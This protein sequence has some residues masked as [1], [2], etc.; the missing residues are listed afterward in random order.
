[1]SLIRI[2]G[3]TIL[4][5]IL[6]ESER[7]EARALREQAIHSQQ[8]RR[9]EYSRQSS[10]L[11]S[12][13]TERER[14][15]N[16]GRTSSSTRRSVLSTPKS[17]RTN[18]ETS[19]SSAPSSGGEALTGPED[20]PSAANV[21]VQTESS[22][23]LTASTD[24][25]SYLNTSLD[26]SLDTSTSA[27]FNTRQQ[28]S[29][30]AQVD[31]ALLLSVSPEVATD[32]ILGR[33]HPSTVLHQSNNDMRNMQPDSQRTDTAS[34]TLTQEQQSAEKQ[35]VPEGHDTTTASVSLSLASFSEEGGD[36]SE[37]GLEASEEILEVSE[38]MDGSEEDRDLSLPSEAESDWHRDE[39]DDSHTQSSQTTS[40]KSGSGSSFDM[41]RDLRVSALREGR[42]SSWSMQRDSG[43]SSS[44]SDYL[45][46]YL[47]LLTSRSSSSLGLQSTGVSVAP[48]KMV[49]PVT[50]SSAT[51]GVITTSSTE[52]SDQKKSS[53][54]RD[55]NNMK[56]KTGS[57]DSSESFGNKEENES[58]KKKKEFLKGKLIEDLKIDDRDKK[59]ARDRLEEPRSSSAASERKTSKRSRERRLSYQHG[60][61]SRS[62]GSKYLDSYLG[63]L[64]D[65]AWL[66]YPTSIGSRH[67][68]FLD[69]DDY[70]QTVRPQQVKKNRGKSQS[71]TEQTESSASEDS[72]R[73]DSS[74]TSSHSPHSNVSTSIKEDVTEMSQ[75][76][77]Q[78]KN[79]S[80][81]LES[82]HTAKVVH[83][84]READAQPLQEQ[85]STFIS[86]PKE[87]M[88]NSETE[89]NEQ[90]LPPNTLS[91]Q[92]SQERMSQC[93]ESTEK[94]DHSPE[95]NDLTQTTIPEKQK[96]NDN[97][98]K[99][100]NSMESKKI[101]SN[102]PDSVNE[103]VIA[104]SSPNKNKIVSSESF[105]KG[106][107]QN[108]EGSFLDDN[109]NVDNVKNLESTVPAF[110]IG[111]IVESTERDDS[112]SDES[113]ETEPSTI[114]YV[115]DYP[116][117]IRNSMQKELEKQGGH[118]TVE[119]D[120]TVLS[121]EKNSEEAKALAEFE[122]LEIAHGRTEGQVSVKSE[123]ET[124][125]QKKDNTD[126]PS[127]H[128]D[129]E[130]YSDSISKNC[131]VTFDGDKDEDNVK[132]NESRTLGE[133]D[134]K[135]DIVLQTE[136][137]TNLAE[138][139]VKQGE[140]KN[141]MDPSF[142]CQV[143]LKSDIVE[144]IPQVE[145]YDS[146]E[147]CLVVQVT[148]RKDSR[149][150]QS[151]WTGSKTESKNEDEVVEIVAQSLEKPNN[152]MELALETSNSMRDLVP[153][154]VS[155]DAMNQ[156]LNLLRAKQ[157]Q[158]L[159]AL[160]RRQEEEIRQFIQQLQRVS[161]KQLQAFLSASTITC[162][163]IEGRPDDDLHLRS[164]GNFSI[165]DVDNFKISK[166][167]GIRGSSPGRSHIEVGLY[168]KNDD[169]SINNEGRG[170]K[171]EQSRYLISSKPVEDVTNK[172]DN[173]SVLHPCAST[174]NTISSSCASVN[175]PS[176]TYSEKI[177]GADLKPRPS[178]HTNIMPSYFV[179]EETKKAADSLGNVVMT[180]EASSNLSNR[181]HNVSYSGSSPNHAQASET[182]PSLHAKNNN[183]PMETL[184]QVSYVNGNCVSYGDGMQYYRLFTAD[185]DG[186]VSRTRSCRQTVLEPVLQSNSSQI[187]T[188]P[189]LFR[190]VSGSP[191]PSPRPTS[192]TG[193]LAEHPEMFSD[194][195]VEMNLQHINDWGPSE[196]G[197][198][199]HTPA[200]QHSS[201]THLVTVPHHSSGRCHSNTS[202]QRG[203]SEE[204]GLD[205]VP[206]RES[207][208]NIYH[209][210][211][212]Q[213]A[214]FIRGITL[215]QAC[216]RRFLIQRLFRTKFVQEQLAILAEI[217][218][219]AQQ[220]H[221]DILTDNIHKGDVDFHKALYNQVVP[222]TPTLHVIPPRLRL[223]SFISSSSYGPLQNQEGMARE[224][225]R[226]V[227]VVLTVQE[228]MSL[229][230]RDRQLWKMQQ[231]RQLPSTSQASPTHTNTVRSR[232]GATEA[233]VRGT[234]TR[235][236]KK[237]PSPP[238]QRSQQE[239]RTRAA[240]HGRTSQLV[241]PSVIT[242]QASNLSSRSSVTSE[243]RVSP[244]GGKLP[245]HVERS[246][247]H[248]D[249]PM[250]HHYM[251]QSPHIRSPSQD[252][253]SGHHTGSTRCSVHPRS[254]SA[255]Q[256]ETRSGSH[257][258]S[259]S[260]SHLPGSHHV[261]RSATHQSGK[262][263][264]RSSS[265]SGTRS[266]CT[267][268]STSMSNS[269]RRV[270]PPRS[271][272]K[273]SLAG[274]RPWR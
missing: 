100:V 76:K 236:A 229:I 129:M 52:H 117:E 185:D 265:I 168:N 28:S 227:F 175:L 178:N 207:A 156:V 73:Q 64:T 234:P 37:E 266:T 25:R 14:A 134:I 65:D 92:Q 245:L 139:I 62:V 170:T 67:M 145:I 69:S 143:P 228:Q 206:E 33:V 132:A 124:D 93:P 41:P 237:R 240:S 99:N 18:G 137:T 216:V 152:E 142:N 10:H 96:E 180:G 262:T 39:T 158:E 133:P 157:R 70:M 105:E 78:E 211:L 226:R 89:R 274:R 81:Q 163:S 94:S 104:S 255:S 16:E 192:I 172:T 8:Q 219:L 51:R 38:V 154:K 196:V 80:C 160:R 217:A 201:G 120:N 128:K 193:L 243:H 82:K 232:S 59:K 184:D 149:N 123:N 112:S 208:A 215:L 253:K 1:M 53:V 103:N 233:R 198:R 109:Y 148:E 44:H 254:S 258:M 29:S 107:Q 187:V 74:T 23:S 63:N 60:D 102:V 181:S 127:S 204:G 138:Q 68:V 269:P 121:R 264:S 122:Q 9:K 84:A 88:E 222:F 116:C 66:Q 98:D 54:C 257:H 261:A 267:A 61:P 194:D 85:D 4:S 230:R 110:K 159:D 171:E 162:G 191:W 260:T 46:D 165:S 248:L 161:P 12:H 55:N 111:N 151:D 202:R 250:S 224:R 72:R 87:S 244:K 221:R 183:M 190:V 15:S 43:R 75:D 11:D 6:S 150:R 174:C 247:S 56:E 220:F 32:L 140:K 147:E 101:S 24:L 263:N 7:L 164:E 169:S 200:T 58:S 3:R 271:A 27:S 141:E 210:P 136:T 30:M 167:R 13:I 125:K 19:S 252:S 34:A 42:E 199:E 119:P 95:M 259:H 126:V 20:S 179:N 114:V 223:P 242:H 203:S 40:Q 118:N 212:S 176:R 249:A 246:S 2:R 57:T 47:E 131:A 22:M 225:I 48:S 213:N 26:T 231:D 146:E 251:K 91:L 97:I 214:I 241:Q 186:H 235:I 173:F 77:K 36:G 35:N 83:P 270:T 113:S 135:D 50:T 86:K 205:M 155:E 49:A 5:P 177:S 218:K 153:E 17:Q 238:H 108:V 90:R 272:S 71:S 182:D 79:V 197:M 45:D 273:T 21:S 256:L 31:E 166:D 195:V 239:G 144:S 188:Q 130:H 115:D 209:H 268:R 189:G 106:T